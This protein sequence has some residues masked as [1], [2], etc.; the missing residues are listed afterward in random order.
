MLEPITLN[1]LSVFCEQRDAAYRIM[2]NISRGISNIV[3][4]AKP[5]CGKTTTFIYLS[6]LVMDE[7]SNQGVKFKIYSLLAD[8]DNE[9]I[10]QTKIRWN[11]AGFNSYH[12][13]DIIKHYH[14]AQFKNLT[15]DPTDQK[16][17]IIVDE[18]HVANKPDSQLHQLFDRLQYDY[19]L[20]SNNSSCENYIISVSATP[21]GQASVSEEDDAANF[22]FVD[23]EASK[24]YYGLKQAQLDGRLRDPI[25]V[26]KKLGS[27]YVVTDEV[28]SI[29]DDFKASGEKKNLVI[30]IGSGKGI[31][32]ELFLDYCESLDL[33]VCEFHSKNKNLNEVEQVISAEPRKPTVIIIYGALRAGKTLETTKYIYAWV[34]SKNSDSDTAYQSAGR[35][36][37]YKTSDGHSK[38]EDRFPIY[39]NKKRLED[40]VEYEKEGVVIPGG[41]V[42]K[43]T[44]IKYIYEPEIAHVDSKTGKYKVYEV[45]NIIGDNGEISIKVRY[46]EEPGDGCHY[47]S[48]E[49]K[50]GTDFPR[51]I[52]DHVQWD[53]RRGIKCDGPNS[54]NQESWDRLTKL[55]P[56]FV[57]TL[58]KIIVMKPVGV[59]IK[60]N[61][62]TFYS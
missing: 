35:L 33:E 26:V 56:A 37:G 38:F 31:K 40:V 20:G 47:T 49:Y 30:R 55:Y 15:L 19:K 25:D 34:D 6:K 32:S 2:S 41:V 18:A 24:E 44:K 27:T 12:Y 59:E 60:N 43:K 48:T 36:F 46:S 23:L 57:N 1:K 8:S 52:C 5:Q 39:A 42:S 50:K 53:R 54:Y 22:Y 13:D 4:R 10:R 28:K 51:I 11:D 61:S 29:L 58:D 21:Y 14:R 3:L 16:R 17:L 7:W 45:E 62:D 9:L